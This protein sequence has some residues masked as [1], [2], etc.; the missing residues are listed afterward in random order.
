MAKFL[1]TA[2]WQLGQKLRRIGGDRGARLRLERFETVRRIARL[3]HERKV[4]AVVVAGDVFDDNAVG[5]ATLQAAR[6]ALAVFRPIP[7]LLLPGNHDAATPD[8][9]LERLAPVEHGLDHVHTLLTAEPLRC[10]GATFHPCPLRRRHS[11]DD[12]TRHLPARGADE[13]VRVA[14]AHGGVL[15][16][17]ETTETPNRI[18]ADAVLGRGFDYLAL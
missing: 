15:D 6:D 8:G 16:F 2:D 17:G 3:A 11:A 10:G 7:V 9:A 4:E 5:D 13:G 1:H 18:D 14:V 12:P